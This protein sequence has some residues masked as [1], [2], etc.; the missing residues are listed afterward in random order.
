MFD[1][2]LF[3]TFFVERQSRL[4]LFS[5]I[6]AFF[7]SHDRLFHAVITISSL[8]DFLNGIH[9]SILQHYEK[10]LKYFS[11]KEIYFLLG[12]IE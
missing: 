10:M 2:L 3:Y 12:F 1:L 4:L 5:F 8:D 9:V 11:Q 6:I 7:A